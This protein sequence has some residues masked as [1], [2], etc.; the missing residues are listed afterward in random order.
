M[1]EEKW[2]YGLPLNESITIDYDIDRM[3]AAPEWK[4]RASFLSHILGKRRYDLTIDLGAGVGEVSLWAAQYSNNVVAFD[5]SHTHC[6]L[7]HF[8][9]WHHHIHNAYIFCGTLDIFGG[10]YCPEPVDL[11]ISYNGLTRSAL[12]EQCPTIDKYL[13]P[14]GI[15]LTVYPKLSFDADD[16]SEGSTTLRDLGLKQGWDDQNFSMSSAMQLEREGDAGK[17]ID[18]LQ[19][20][21]KMSDLPALYDFE[22]GRPTDV[23]KGET[24]IPLHLEYRLYRKED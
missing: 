4:E 14:G 16:T 12:L 19:Y 24:E 17:E 13:K 10:K 1:G 21:V 11:V 5:L 23:W 9:M 2:F 22:C 20:M 8:V 3:V 18:S 7:Y 15:F 6:F